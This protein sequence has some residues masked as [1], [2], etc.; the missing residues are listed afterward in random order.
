MVEHTP[1]P[2]RTGTK[3][4]MADPLYIEAGEGVNFTIIGKARTLADA[5]LIAA[6]P[7]LLAACERAVDL[8]HKYANDASS[9][10]TSTIRVIR[11]ELRAAIAKA[12]GHE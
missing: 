3:R 2:W 12:T 7:D 5:R 1:G 4:Y 6:A 10:R 9:H 8:L 11:D